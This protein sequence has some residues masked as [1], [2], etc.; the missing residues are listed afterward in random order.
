MTKKRCQH[1]GALL[2]PEDDLFA[3][4]AKS[5]RERIQD[6]LYDILR[7]GVPPP[8]PKQQR[9]FEEAV[10][11]LVMEFKG[12]HGY[13][14]KQPLDHNLT[15]KIIAAIRQA[16][17]EKGNAYPFKGNRSPNT[18]II[19]CIVD[20][21]IEDKG[22]AAA[23]ATDLGYAERSQ[24]Y[25]EAIPEP[26]AEEQRWDSASEVLRGGMDHG[27]FLHLFAGADLISL[28]P[29]VLEVRDERVKETLEFRWADRVATAL[30][31]ESVQF[32]IAGRAISIRPMTLD[33]DDR[34]D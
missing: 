14:K 29:A 26:T 19:D 23:R 16:Y 34:N 4:I 32:R 11:T 15:S 3:E 20:A 33:D 8:A 12:L 25:R 6:V 17:E 5:N 30:G 22:K 9:A 21:G 10:D 24:A 27:T 28:E 13:T 31:V 7:D 18:P 2:D 1:C